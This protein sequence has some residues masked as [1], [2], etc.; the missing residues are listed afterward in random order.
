[1]MTPKTYLQCS[2]ILKRLGSKPN[3][4]AT[5]VEVDEGIRMEVDA[6]IFK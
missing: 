1:M 5:D 6:F 4:I 3:Q 2:W